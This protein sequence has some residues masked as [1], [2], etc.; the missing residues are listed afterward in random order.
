MA[1][2]YGCPALAAIVRPGLI[3]TLTLTTDPDP[4]LDPDPDPDPNPNLGEARAVGCGTAE[5]AGVSTGGACLPAVIVTLE[6]PVMPA[7]FAAA[8]LTAWV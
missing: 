6:P 7:G 3:L 8:P 1:I 4:N 2:V 5:T